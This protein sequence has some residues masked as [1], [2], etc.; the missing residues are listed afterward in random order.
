MVKCGLNLY[1]AQ[2]L[3]PRQESTGIDVV[4]DVVQGQTGYLIR[5]SEED[6]RGLPAIAAV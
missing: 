2:Q 1:R 3:H 4:H 6:G 5:Q